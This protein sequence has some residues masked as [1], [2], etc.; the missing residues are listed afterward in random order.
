MEK[1]T[2]EE[3]KKKKVLEDYTKLMI[4]IG[5]C[6]FYEKEYEKAITYF[7]VQIES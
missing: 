3:L 7:K 6:Y 5:N 4:N 2:K 1:Y